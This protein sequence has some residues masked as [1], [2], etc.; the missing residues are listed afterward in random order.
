MRR[1]TLPHFSLSPSLPFP[2]QSRT[3]TRATASLRAAEPRASGVATSPGHR[4]G[5]V[6][7]FRILAIP[8]AVIEAWGRAK[9]LEDFFDDAERRAR[10]LEPDESEAA[11]DRIRQARA[12]LG[13]GDALRRLLSWR[14]PEER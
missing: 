7:P 1:S 3:P 6:R 8:F 12:L 2:F 5:R 14:S 9:Q 13:D 10:T 4:T 11:L